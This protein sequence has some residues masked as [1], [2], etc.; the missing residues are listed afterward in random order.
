MP[1]FLHFDFFFFASVSFG[2]LK[3]GMKLQLSLAVLLD[4][5]LELIRILLIFRHAWS[6]R[7][8]KEK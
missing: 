1:R 4:V 8:R 7:V 6:L 5:F 2:F 3:K